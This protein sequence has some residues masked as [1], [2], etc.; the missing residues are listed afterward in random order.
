ML[1]RHDQPPTPPINL[2]ADFAGGS[3]TCALGILAA[4]VNRASSVSGAAQLPA[5]LRACVCVHV[6]VLSSGLSRYSA[7]AGKGTSSRCGHG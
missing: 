7:H 5:V 4:V 3:L 1:G 2:L 6:R